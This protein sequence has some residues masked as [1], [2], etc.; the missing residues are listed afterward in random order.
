MQL[1]DM[2]HINFT[3]SIIIGL[4]IGGV[5]LYGL[6]AGHAKVRTLAMSTYVGIVLA[7]MVSEPVHKLVPGLDM[8]ILRLI[9]FAAPIFLLELSRRH[10]AKGVHAGMIV[11]MILAVLTGCLIVGM[12]IAQLEGDALKGI[13]DNSIVAFELYTYRVWLV[14]VVP[15]F[16]VAE[17]FINQAKKEKH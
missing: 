7:S 5:V 4:V 10:H 15:V 17:A 11:T 14:A 8:G 9:L 3:T 16:I 13:T 12:G 1:P 6:M 2:P